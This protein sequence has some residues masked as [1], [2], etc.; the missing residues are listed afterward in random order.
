MLQ[1]DKQEFLRSLQETAGQGGMSNT[2]DFSPRSKHVFDLARE[3]AVEQKVNYI[4]TEH[5]LIGILREHEGYGAQ[6]LSQSGITED[7]VWELLVDNSNVAPSSGPMASVAAKVLMP[8]E[9]VVILP[10]RNWIKIVVT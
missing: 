2:L 3:A 9:R 10:L 8:V 6:A 5:I 7:R 4:A 1:F